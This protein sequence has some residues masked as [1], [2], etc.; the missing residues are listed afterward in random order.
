MAE[1]NGP[2][3]PGERVLFDTHPRFTFTLGSTLVKIIILII[4]IYVFM[5]LVAAVATLQNY[6]INFVR[7][8]L[9]EGFSY[10]LIFL[11]VILFLWI[12]WDIV[13]WRAI[14]YT[15][16]DRRVVIQRGVIRKKKVYIH[17]EKI[18][19][20]NISQGLMERLFRAGDIEIYSGHDRTQL[21]L[22]DVPNPAEVDNMI[23]RLIEGEDVGF[24]KYKRSEDRKSVIDQY[25]RK[26]KE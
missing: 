1:R 3:H 15:L 25:D 10:L 24:R 9:V 13:S 7:L 23:N 8:P 26:F 11:V 12:L 2:S 6:L 5:A 18:Q 14:H 16:T 20:I 22:N 21:I 19:D 4:L 17:Y